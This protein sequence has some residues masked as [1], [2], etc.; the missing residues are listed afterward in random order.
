MI[1]RNRSFMLAVIMSFQVMTREKGKR[2]KKGHKQPFRIGVLVS[3]SNG[4][5]IRTPRM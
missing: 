3:P 1:H 4:I 2:G 5:E